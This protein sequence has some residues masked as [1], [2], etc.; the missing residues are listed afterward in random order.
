MALDP[1]ELLKMLPDNIPFSAGALFK[2]TS[3]DKLQELH[4]RVFLII[5][6]KNE[7]D[8]LKIRGTLYEEPKLIQELIRTVRP[9]PPAIFTIDEK[10]LNQ[11]TTV[12]KIIGPDGEEMDGPE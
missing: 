11:N 12:A 2:W 10:L 8:A 9:W 3:L 6:T 7:V 1:E 4:G 5:Q